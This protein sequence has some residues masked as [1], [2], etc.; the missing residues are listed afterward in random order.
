MFFKII[1]MIFCCAIVLVCIIGLVA[2]TH[3]HMDFLR[4]LKIING[5]KQKY[6][7]KTIKK[8]DNYIDQHY[9]YEDELEDE[10][11]DYQECYNKYKKDKIDSISRDWVIKKR[12]NELNQV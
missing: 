11:I 10:E 7:N 2:I 12:I 9:L 4:F 8:F 3:K 6:V 1:I 5:K